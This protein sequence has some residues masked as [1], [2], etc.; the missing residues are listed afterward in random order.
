M[1]DGAGN[2]NADTSELTRSFSSLRPTVSLSSTATNPTNTSPIHVTAVF[3]VNVNGF[4][5]EDLDGHVTNATVSNFAGSGAS[6]SFD[7]TPSSDSTVSVVIPASAVVD[8][9][10]NTN[11]NF[12]SPLFSL[13][14]DS[15]APTLSEVSAVASLSTNKTPT[16]TFS[17][18]EAGTITYGGGCTSGS[19]SASSGN[20]TITFSTLADGTYICTV[21]VTDA[22]HNAR[23]LTLSS[24]TID[25]TAP[26]ISNLSINPSA[27]GATVR[28]DTNENTSSQVLYGLTTSY[29]TQS[30]EG[31]TSPR[32][33][34]HQVTLSGLVSCATYHYTASS[35]DAALNN[36]VGSDDTFTTRGCAGNAN[37]KSQ[38]S[39]SVTRSAGGSATLNASDI[40]VSLSIPA[41][42]GSTDAQF[43]IKQLEKST[44]LDAIGSPSTDVT[45]AGQVIDLHALTTVDTAQTSFDTQLTV[46]L[47]YTAA[48]VA[49]LD[50]STL[51]IYRNDSGVWTALTSCSI[52]RTAKT[53]TCNTDHF[54][55]FAIFGQTTSSDSGNT[56]SQNTIVVSGNG[57]VSG[58]LSFGFS[59]SAAATSSSVYQFTRFLKSGVIGDD[60]KQ[61]QIFLNTHGFPLAATGTSSPGQETMKFGAN[62]RKALIRFQEAHA[63][64]ILAPQDLSQGTGN[65]FFYSMTFINSMLRAEGKTTSTGSTTTTQ[66]ST[67]T[68]N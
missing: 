16:F 30:S 17:S 41:A 47:N 66:V 45:A 64:E 26:V 24:F 15:T 19:T 33:T 32:V 50:E 42:F 68:H 31:D 4:A 67:T 13:V 12:A 22:A 61:L 18:S 38:S 3:S 21:T 57:A 10:T 65:F 52:D 14:Y 25:T 29:G 6:Y 39:R 1:Q 62:T 36:S 7:L 48:D 20:N 46:T 11:P 40:G 23:M 59:A 51:K 5:V 53:V 8:S 35:S 34:S 55:T 49:N 58:P 56:T 54:S 63:R 2:T 27:N 37:V 9:D 43:Q 28:W 44:A 60:V